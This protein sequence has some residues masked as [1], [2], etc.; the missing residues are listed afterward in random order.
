MQRLSLHPEADV[1]LTEVARYYE[2]QQPGLGVEFLAEV[3]AAVVG[4]KRAPE[5]FAVRADGARRCPLHRFPHRLVY[6]IE[7]DVLRIYAIA[8]P[9]R[10]PGYWLERL[11][12]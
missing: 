4:L 9:S 7:G 6:R 2:A 3:N 10:R 8:H 5:I 1:E 12:N 11:T